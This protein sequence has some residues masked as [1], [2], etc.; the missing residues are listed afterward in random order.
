M[1]RR[2]SSCVRGVARALSRGFVCLAALVAGGTGV[3]GQV[4]DGIGPDGRERVAAFLGSHC[5]ACHEGDSPEGDVT[6]VIPL[7]DTALRH[8]RR[9]WETAVRRTVA[10]E[11]PPADHPR[12]APAE[13]EAFAAAVRGLLAEADRRAPP[14]PGRVTMRRL[15][16][17]EYKNTVRDLLQI[18]FDPTDDFPGDEI[19]YGF[20]TVGDALS[21]PP[22]LLERYLD[23]AEAVM[24][25]TIP[26]PP[27]E[28]RKRVCHENNLL[29]SVPQE[30]QESLLING[31]RQLSTA[32]SEAFATG[33]IHTTFDREAWEADGDYECVIRAYA[34]PDSPRPSGT[35]RIFFGSDGAGD[36]VIRAIS[37]QSVTGSDAFANTFV[38]ATSGATFQLVV[39]IDPSTGYTMWV[40]P[41]GFNSVNGTP[42]GGTSA[43]MT[44][45][46]LQFSFDT[47]QLGGD[48]PTNTN[49]SVTFDEFR[50]GTTAA[51]V[52]PEPSTYAMALAGLA[53][54]GSV[55]FRR[56]RRRGPGGPRGPA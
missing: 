15:N 22:L 13:T 45:N 29:P 32:S 56:C 26:V 28:K 42:T 6:L 23:A 4:S 48:D 9:I 43:S 50:M 5:A 8:D 24:Q 31:Y 10:G 47:I 36:F 7:N 53:C 27:P 41:T 49:G 46:L 34:S 33:P 51:A 20:D 25:R 55:V 17:H 12:P 38:G 40:N 18:D 21:L 1:P 54:G 2:L 30:Q 19:A 14:D 3:L 16:R 39:N 37:G 11:M 35:S 52:V 44:S